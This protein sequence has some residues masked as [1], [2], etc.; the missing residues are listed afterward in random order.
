MMQY[1]FAK[2]KKD[3]KKEEENAK[4]MIMDEKKIIKT[5]DVV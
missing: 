2:T 5:S 3:G 1:F 4:N